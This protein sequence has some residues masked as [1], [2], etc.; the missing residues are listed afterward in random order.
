MPDPDEVVAARG[1]YLHVLAGYVQGTRAEF[2]AREVVREGGGG[3]AA[4]W[5]KLVDQ[6]RE[7]YLEALSAAGLEPPYADSGS[8]ADDESVTDEIVAIHA[9]MEVAVAA[10]N[11]ASAALFESIMHEEAVFLAESAEQLLR[12]QSV[13]INRPQGVV[14]AHV[15]G[16]GEQT[17]VRFD[18]KSATGRGGWI[19]VAFSIVPPAERRAALIRVLAVQLLNLMESAAS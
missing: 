16:A 19:E 12:G 13:L 7:R 1:F 11:K 6:V 8:E 9:E 18:T 10:R 2:E 15:M 4:M 17:V 3:W 5:L 14:G